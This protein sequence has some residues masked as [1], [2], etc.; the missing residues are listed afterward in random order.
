MK[1]SVILLM[2]KNYFTKQFPFPTI[3]VVT[4]IVVFRNVYVSDNW[5]YSIRKIAK[6]GAVN[7][8]AGGSRGSADGDGTNAQFILPGAIAIDGQGNVYV[9]D[10]TRIRKIT[11]TGN[12]TTLAGGLT[13]DY[14]DGVG[15]NSR[16]SFIGSIAVDKQGTLYVID[17]DLATYRWVGKCLCNS[18]WN[19]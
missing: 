5:K 14:A 6:D 13:A 11:P 15:T 16:F 3:M 9:A 8:L 18:I 2:P 17:Q 12:V 1:K 19:S 7:T 10:S 4:T